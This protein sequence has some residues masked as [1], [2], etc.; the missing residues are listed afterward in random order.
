MKNLPKKI[1]K[2]ITL[3][4]YFDECKVGKESLLKIIE[5]VEVAHEQPTT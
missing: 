1:Q 5:E 2:L 4:K 3:K